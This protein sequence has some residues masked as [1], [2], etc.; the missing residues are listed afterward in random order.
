GRL[1]LAH[2]QCFHII[3]MRLTFIRQS[4]LITKRDAMRPTLARMMCVSF[5]AVFGV[6]VGPA[7]SAQLSQGPVVHHELVVTLE[8]ATHRLKVRDR[9]RI[10]GAF[11]TS[12]FTISLNADLNVLA[13]SGGLKLIPIR[14]HALGSDS[15]LGRNDHDPVSRVPVNVYRVE[16][17]MPGQELNSEL[18]YEGVINYTVRESGSEYARAF[19]QSPGLIES[20]GVYLAGSTHWVPQ[21]GDALTT[22]TLA[23][24]LPAGWK[25]VS[26]GER[27][28]GGPP[29]PPR[30]DGKGSGMSERWSVATPTEEVHLIAAP[31]TEF[32][33]DVGAVKAFAFLRKPDQALAD[34]Y[35]DATAQY[36]EMYSGL[37]GPYPYSKFALVENF[38]QTGY[39]MPS[40]TLLG[41][42]IIRF[43]FILHSSYPHELLHN[44]WGNGVFVDLAGGNWCEGLTAYLA[45]HL[46]AEQR[47]QGADHRRAI[48]QRV[49][50]YVTPENDFPV[51]RF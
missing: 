18:N 42:E 11:V 19:S 5:L 1:R 16:G 3:E 26:Q 49:T 43:P 46:I 24:E 48:L 45:D 15:A 20:R 32:S 9:I 30:G 27:T 41:D 34:R 13:V 12:P 37:L 23:V 6:V 38:W 2:P 17:A 14:T 29:S 51:S 35:L 21:V 47:G 28:S 36:L 7:A 40:F 10:P 4:A 31:F 22:Y 33:K 44:W 50:N 8:P 25:S 39:G